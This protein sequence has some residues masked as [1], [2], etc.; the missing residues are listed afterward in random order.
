M[1]VADLKD[2]STHF[3]FGE[4][5]RNYAAHIDASAIAEAEKGLLKLIAPEHLHNS[6]FLDIGCGS[7]LHSLAALR[8]GVAEVVAIDLDLNSVETARNVLNLHAPVAKFDV[9]Q[10]SVF[11]QKLSELGKFDIVYSW[12]VL[13]H[14]GDMWVAVDKAAGCVKPGG[15][16]VLALYQKRL[17]CGAWKIE[18]R[19]Y[20]NSPPFIQ[21]IVKGLFCGAF[22]LG[23]LVTGRNPMK[24]V[25][26][27][28]SARGM[29]FFNDV[30]DWL[31][32]YPY[33]SATPAEVEEHLAC[34]NF[35]KLRSF[36]IKKGFG[37][38][39]TGCAEYTFRKND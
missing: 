2:V 23:L 27:Y 26:N 16:F 33:E 36:P 14:T 34:N 37:L 24:Y 8:L 5:W 6:R 7:G 20:T 15:I 19:L 31:G 21:S 39:G 17:T 28:K 18:K 30:H 10:L 3:S 32:G 1:A 12:G 29:N 38:F 13:H 4:N 11:D 22:M 9:K 35:E 25:R